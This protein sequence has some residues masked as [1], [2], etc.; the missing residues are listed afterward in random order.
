MGNSHCSYCGKP[1]NGRSDRFC[2]DECEDRYL[3]NEF[4]QRQEQQMMDRFDENVP[5]G[6]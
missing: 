3:E 1:K 6:V 5:S 2:S 4:R